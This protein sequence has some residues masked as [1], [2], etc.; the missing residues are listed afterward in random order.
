MKCRPL[1]EVIS[2]GALYVDI[3]DNKALAYDL[4]VQSFT[5]IA[6]GHRVNLSTI[7]KRYRLS[8]EIVNGLTISICSL[9]NLCD[10]RERDL[11]DDL[12][13]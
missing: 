6:S 7:V 8:L 1:S 11:N 4:V 13:C 10:G 9:S 2:E 12:I 5:G 3:H